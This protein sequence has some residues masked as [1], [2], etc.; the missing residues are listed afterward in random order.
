MA[1]RHK[2]ARIQEGVEVDLTPMIDV[3]FLLIIFFILVTTITT[4]D[5]VNLRLPDALAANVED[6]DAAKLFTVHIA[7]VDQYSDEAMPTQFGFFAY[8]HPDPKGLDELR[9]IIQ[10]EGDRIDREIG[11]DGRV[12]GRISEN[13]IVIRSDARAPSQHFGQLIEIMA[14]S[15]VYRMKIAILNDPRL[16][17]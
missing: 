16:E 6:P 13:Q 8:G 3:V 17:N 5:N 7:P 15:M 11:Y 10:R 12:D 14:E 4:Q 1:R 9:S 2:K